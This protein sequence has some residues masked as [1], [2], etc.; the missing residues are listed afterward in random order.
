MTDQQSTGP[1]K[2][3]VSVVT[4]VY[5]GVDHLED[6]IQSVLGQTYENI[7]YIV[8]DGESTDGSVDIIKQ[9]ADQLAE[10]VSERDEG[11]YDAMSKGIRRANGDIVGLVNADDFYEPETAR[12]VAE[13]HELHPESIITGAMRRVMDDG[14]TYTLRKNLSTSYLDKTIRYT[15]PVNHPATFV[16]AT[17]YQELGLFDTELSI[18]GDYEFVCRAYQQNVPFVFVDQVLSNM[19]VGGLSSG[20]NNVLKRAQERY[21]VRQ[22]HEMVSPLG[23]AAL[24][25]QWLL[26][27]VMKGAVKKVMPDALQARL[28]ATRHGQAT[29]AG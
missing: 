8:I 4:V 10:W 20:A 6:C 21:K 1:G 24:S 14:S 5:N 15:M 22:K 18:L 16:P 25:A 29:G 13:T 27:T 9:Y 11:V 7:E 19:R 2:P 12:I 28:Y 23:N 17:V 26:S 3:L